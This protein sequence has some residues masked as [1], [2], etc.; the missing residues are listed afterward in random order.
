MA[1]NTFVSTYELLIKPINQGP[2]PNRTVIQGYFL[3]ISNTSFSNLTIRLTFKG[4]SP[5]LASTTLAAF[6][7]VVGV[8]VQPPLLGGDCFRNCTFDLPSQD[9]GLFLLQPDF[10]IDP[11]LIS[12][13]DTE[14]RGYVSLTIEA[15][16][17]IPAEN[18][19]RTLLLS[20]QQRGT[21]LPEDIDNP[22]LPLPNIGDYDQLAYSL[23]L[24]TGGS[25]VTLEPLNITPPAAIALP[26]QEEIFKAIEENPSFLSEITSHPLAQ[27][28]A[29]LSVE[30]QQRIL[31]VFLER[32]RV[33]PQ[34]T[35]ASN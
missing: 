13:Q 11:M 2:P 35:P 19:M 1:T 34:T 5:D 22:A 21:F 33:S 23:P 3:T 8:E 31:P 26:S 28:I 29:K 4:C 27:Q 12:N 18:N 30:E 6:W 14:I 24:A 10:A 20:A 7:D 15:A 9:T 17:E 25:E 16:S 32:F